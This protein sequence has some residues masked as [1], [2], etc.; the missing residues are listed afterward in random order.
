MYIINKCRYI[1]LTFLLVGGTAFGQE[2]KLTQKQKENITR[3]GYILKKN[4]NIGMRHPDH[5]W[6]KG[7]ITREVYFEFSL[8]NNGILKEGRIGHIAKQDPLYDRCV[9]HFNE[10]GC[11]DFIEIHKKEHDSDEDRLKGMNIVKFELGKHI[12]R[13]DKIFVTDAPFPSWEEAKLFLEHIRILKFR[14]K[15]EV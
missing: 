11:I 5:V 2:F 15:S 12:L 14:K 8:N 7:S 1:I 3:A 4:L 10:F 9:Y 6:F 13:S